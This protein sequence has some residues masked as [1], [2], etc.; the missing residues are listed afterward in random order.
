MKKV[1]LVSLAT[2]ALA[3]CSTVSNFF[4]QEEEISNSQR[5][6]I[7]CEAWGSVFRRIDDRDVYGLAS[8]IEVKAVSTALPYLNAVCTQDV[9]AV[10]DFNV[11]LLEKAVVRVLT[12]EDQSE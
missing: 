2:V 8:D 6:L 5:L 1:L 4:S 12:A 7:V 3:G 10:G 9:E 11:N